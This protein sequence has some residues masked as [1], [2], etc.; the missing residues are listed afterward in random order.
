MEDMHAFNPAVGGQT[1]S[2]WGILT[3][4]YHHNQDLLPKL[5]NIGIFQ[6]N[7]VQYWEI[8]PYIFILAP[9]SCVVTAK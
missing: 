8:S 5:S 7:L 2:S 4:K 3:A 1:P 6:Q 9:G